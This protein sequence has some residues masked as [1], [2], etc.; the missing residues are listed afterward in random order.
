MF[1]LLIPSLTSWLNSVSI[2]QYHTLK[3]R[4]VGSKCQKRK[5]IRWYNRTLEKWKDVSPSYIFCNLFTKRVLLII[6]EY[7]VINNVIS[8]YFVPFSTTY[9]LPLFETLFNLLVTLLFPTFKF[10]TLYF[11]SRL[12]VLQYITKVK[13]RVKGPEISTLL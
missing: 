8:H 9:S 5:L 13:T 12:I 11:W 6:S 3:L 2:I 4:S 10:V 1:T 7:N